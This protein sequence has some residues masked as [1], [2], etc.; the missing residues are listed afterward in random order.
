MDIDIGARTR[1]CR[2]K[3]KP[4]GKWVKAACEGATTP[5]DLTIPHPGPFQS[6]PL[7]SS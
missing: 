6:L 2:E 7:L 4:V 3:Y 5:L 1:R